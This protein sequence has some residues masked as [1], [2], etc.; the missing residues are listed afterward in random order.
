MTMNRTTT[1]NLAKLTRPRLF[2]A[3]ARERLFGRLDEGRD[4]PVTWISGP[5]GAG[6]TTLTASYLDA[7]DLPALW[8]QVDA[9]DA[10][11]A[12]VFHYLA[13]AAGTFQ[14]AGDPPLPM[15]EAI[16]ATDIAGF[17]R[18]F[19]REYFARLPSPCALVFDNYQEVPPEAPLHPVL[20]LA[21]NEI[22]PGQSLIVV[23]RGAPPVEFARLIANNCLALVDWASL[24]LDAAEARAM[25]RSRMPLSDEACSSLFERS[26]GWAAGV[27][28]L[29]EQQRQG[30]DFGQSRMEGHLFDYFAGEIFDRASPRVQQFLLSTAAVPVMTVRTAEGITGDPAAGEILEDMYRRNL[31][32]QRIPAAA[33]AYQ[34]HALFREF[35]HSRALAGREVQARLETARR[36][37]ALLEGEGLDEEAFGAYREGEDWPAAVALVLRQAA[38][39]AAQGRSRTLQDWIAALPADRLASHPWLQYWFGV[40]LA[41]TD[42][43][44]AR[45]R[46]DE[47]FTLFRAFGDLK[48][49]MRA[50][51]SQIELIYFEWSNFRP[52][53]PWIGEI[54][55]LIEAG[56]MFESETDELR[57][58][59]SLLIAM[60]YAMPGH[61]KLASLCDRVEVLLDGGAELAQKRVAATFLVSHLCLSRQLD[62]CQG[63][64][65]RVR[66]WFEASDASPMALLWWHTRLGFY[67]YLQTDFDTADRHLATTH[68]LVSR[69]GLRG[70]RTAIALVLSYQILND[71]G[72]RDR[73]ATRLHVELAE[74]EA[75][76]GRSMGMWSKLVAQC[77]KALSEDNYEMAAGVGESLLRVAN[78]SGM[79]YLSVLAGVMYSHALVQCGRTERLEEVVERT[80]TIVRGTCLDHWEVDLDLVR[81]RARQRQGDTAIA[82]DMLRAALATARQTDYRYMYFFSRAFYGEVFALALAHGIE[83]DYVRSTITRYGTTPPGVEVPHWPWTVQVFTLGR[84]EVWCNG[85]RTEFSGKAPR[86]VLSLLKAIVAYGGEQ[87]PD[88]Q[89]IDALWPDEDADA[90]QKSLGVA[91]TRLRKLLGHA[92]AVMRDDQRVSLNPRLCWI[93]AMA[94]KRFVANT[95]RALAGAE[96]ARL[97]SSVH[98]VTSLYRGVFLPDDGEEFWTIPARERL[99][100]LFTSFTEELGLR[101]ESAGCWLDATECYRAGLDVD[102]L[103][104][105]LYRGLMRAFRALDRAADAMAAFRRMRQMLSVVLGI[106]PS[107]ESEALARLIAD[108]RRIS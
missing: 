87:V 14:R 102:D 31:F 54:E 48:G 89:L 40:S 42:P 21:L 96:P 82:V 80:S 38:T 10:D 79:H 23:S 75:Q 56:A 41:V 67:H 103:N 8:Y 105:T 13:L 106:Q 33:P 72:L 55:S 34:F 1:S 88:K 15:F 62:R 90:A 63:L 20:A 44:S 49:A 36:A 93:D 70:M 58:N 104:E 98:S 7:R 66:L 76:G 107:P 43:A 2:G 16:F 6:K 59:G 29:I 53:V 17:A 92:E 27:T 9:G 65:A 91:L 46:F 45:R 52:L 100:A 81:A 12:T 25:V 22:P 94:L 86:K 60:L 69:Y 50:A 19:F 73:G 18:R 32:V 77:M 97:L 28:L 30:G 57:V 85:E 35:L 61:R 39:L 84:F 4:R 71:Q 24:R 51:C 5:P 108:E 47:A 95:E 101:L 64:I 83:T 11:V 74:H 78:E 3:V 68:E 37:G 99:R 26:G